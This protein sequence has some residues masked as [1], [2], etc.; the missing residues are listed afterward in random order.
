MSEEDIIQ[1]LTKSHAD[2]NSKITHMST[3]LSLLVVFARTNGIQLDIM[4]LW[5]LFQQIPRETEEPVMH[6]RICL[7]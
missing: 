6:V 3:S 4:K 5:K 1:L 7:N 2:A